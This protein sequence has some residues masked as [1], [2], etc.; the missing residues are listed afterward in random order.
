MAADSTCTALV[1]GA[2]AMRC[3]P[4][5]VLCLAVTIGG[6]DSRAQEAAATPAP[7]P[8]DPCATP[9]PPKPCHPCLTKW[10]LFKCLHPA[11]CAPAPKVTV[12]VP[13]PEVIVRQAPP[14]A[15]PPRAA[16]PPAPPTQQTVPFLVPQTT[17]SMVPVVTMQAVPT[18]SYQVVHGTVPAQG[19]APV[20]AAAPVPVA[21][22]AL[23]PCS[24]AEFARLMKTLAAAKGAARDCDTSK[25]FTPKALADAHAALDAEL[26]AEIA[27][28]EDM[29]KRSTLTLADQTRAAIDGLRGETYNKDEVD[30]KFND[31]VEKLKAN[32]TL[33]DLLTK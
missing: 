3:R 31:L 17:Y 30:K 14:K 7:T 29:I 12:V 23:P 9:C 19:F 10:N 6:A 24:D 27:R 16:V 8:A 25:E 11:K 22:A 2:I 13:Q 32:P 33:K 28:L 21:P 15:A 5:L 20:P 26:K 1:A 18:V 4:V